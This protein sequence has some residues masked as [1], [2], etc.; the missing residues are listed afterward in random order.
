MIEGLQQMLTGSIAM[1]WF[2]VG[3]FFLKF[4]HHTRDPFFLWFALSFCIEALNRVFLGV[5]AGSSEN[6]PLFYGIRVVSYGLILF[7]IWQKNR[8]RE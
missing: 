6:D 1:G 5:T 8:P 3:L 7:A 2:V 4:W